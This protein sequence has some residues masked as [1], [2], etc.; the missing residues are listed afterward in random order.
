M[1]RRAQ[2]KARLSTLNPDFSMKLRGKL[3][4]K[5]RSKTQDERYAKK[6]A[7][8]W[9]RRQELIDC[10]PNP[11]SGIELAVAAAS[12]IGKMQPRQ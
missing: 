12:L 1:H 6:R 4:Q 7:A 9:A 11:L 5:H 8:R 10:Q 3:K 2:T